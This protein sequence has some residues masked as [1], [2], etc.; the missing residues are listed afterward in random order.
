M[1][2]SKTVLFSLLIIVLSGGAARVLAQNV[3]EVYPE[4]FG[5]LR[6][7]ITDDSAAINAAIQS[8]PATGGTLRCHDGTYLLGGTVIYR[9]NLTIEG[10]NTTVFKRSSA[11]TRPLF[12]CP[13]NT[14]VDNVTFRNFTIDGNKAA[15][16]SIGCNP[17]ILIQPSGGNYLISRVLI[18]NLYIHDS[19]AHPIFIRGLAKPY[20]WGRRG[21]GD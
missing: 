15:M 20:L 2:L 11:N 9:S 13:G 10:Q 7:G 6:D 18:E 19:Y 8:L 1:K 12:Q 16:G 17:D 4:M 14:S 3:A 21:Q 5:A